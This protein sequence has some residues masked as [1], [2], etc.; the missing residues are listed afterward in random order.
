MPPGSQPNTFPWSGKIIPWSATLRS[1]P[2]HGARPLADLPRGE[3]IK[4]LLRSGGWLYVECHLESRNLLKGY[5]SQE[6]IKHVRPSKTTDDGV[7]KDIKADITPQHVG[8]QPQQA[9]TP[10]SLPSVEF[11]LAQPKIIAIATDTYLTPTM[12]VADPQLPGGYALG[13]GQDLSFSKGRKQPHGPSVGTTT[14]VLDGKMRLLLSEFAKSD[15][16]GKARRLFDAFL[17]P[18]QAVAFWSDKGLTADAEVH[19]NI[20]TFVHRALSAPNSPERTAGQIRIHQALERA[21]W[22][23]NAATPATGLGVPAFNQGSPAWHTGD[24]NNGLG[25]MINGIQHA[26]VVAKAYHFDRTKKEYYLK[27]EYVFY[28]VFGLDDDDMR[29]Y[30]ADGGWFESNAAQGITA[31]WQLQHQHGYAPLITRIAFEREF[32]VPIPLEKETRR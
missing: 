26:I 4:V 10:P 5:V 17:K 12:Y 28:D 24:F 21:G 8:A 1:K 31:W 20:V 23:I 32:R 25:V 16:R 13:F 6:L 15:T 14:T 22:D 7:R 29:E 30:G 3:P 9:Q 27:L 11:Q 19:P 2:A 18:Q